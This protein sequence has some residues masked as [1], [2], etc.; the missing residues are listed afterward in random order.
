M[1]N[2]S[3]INTDNLF[4]GENK[5]ESTSSNGSG[6][7]VMGVANNDKSIIAKKQDNINQEN[8]Q[9]EDIL[10]I[11]E[12][13]KSMV[14]SIPD[15]IDLV[16]VLKKELNDS[17]QKY[18]TKT[19]GLKITKIPDDVYIVAMVY[20]L[21]K[22]TKN[23]GWDM[24]RENDF[25]YLY[26]GK[27]WEECT[28]DD[29]YNFFKHIA[30]KMNFYHPSKAETHKFKEDFYKQFL[31]SAGF[32][33]PNT[34]KDIVL[35]NCSNGTLEVT[36]N[37]VKLRQHN[38]K[39]FLKYVLHFDYDKTAKA[40]IFEKYLNDVLDADSQKVLQEFCGY[41]FVS[42]L[43]LEK[44]LV[45]YG[46]GANGKSVFFEIINSLLGRENIATKSLGDLTD[47][48]QGSYNRAMIKDSLLNYGSE[49][50]GKN[51]DVD[52]FKRLISGEPVQ[53]RLPY[54]RPF[55]LK[56]N[57][58]FMFNANELPKVDEH[59]EAVFR[60]FLIVPFDVTIPKDKRDSELHN[61]IVSNELSGV[62]NWVLVGLERLL[63]NKEFTVSQKVEDAL[64]QYKKESDSVALFVDESEYIPS[65]DNDDFKPTRSLY[66]EYK[67][68]TKENGQY[69]LGKNKF[70]ARFKALGFNPHNNGDSRG[71]LVE[72][73]I[74][75]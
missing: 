62:L 40:P 7:E 59:N 54:A 36:Q 32:Y 45:C 57:T 69:P 9:K 37:K 31:A 3:N 25:I 39:D 8:Q 67:D 6:D 2:F 71:Y 28:K 1:S 64:S 24:A 66:N 41:V 58:K 70:S 68:L 42:N 44:C 72:K 49:I 74:L 10:S 17:L 34:N 4:S 63:K 13:L 18:Y 75:K 65:M 52:I 11:N 26:N 38:K 50:K 12:I 30:K 35:L 56:N 19:E 20:K 48:S 43:K 46:S 5:V 47:N 60:R 29:L 55:D 33:K 73:K 53:A 51:I 21:L 14:R 61:K 22:I 23:K 27:Y 16:S 15:N